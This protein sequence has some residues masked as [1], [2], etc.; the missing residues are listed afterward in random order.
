LFYHEHNRDEAIRELG[1]AIEL[2][3]AYSTAYHWIALMLSAMGRHEEAVRNI[4]K[5][6]ELEPR[7][8]IIQTAA[9][10]VYFYA[11]KYDDALGVADKV[12]ENNEG[13]VPAYKTKRIVFE[14]TGNFS[15][16]LTAYQ[17]ERIYSENT[18]EDDAGWMMIAA[19]VQA[20]GGN[21][22]EAVSNLKRATESAFVKSNLKSFAYEIAL[23]YALLGD[24][25]AT[26]E[27]LKKAKEVNSYGFN[28]AQVD[29]R[30]DKVRENSQFN[31]LFKNQ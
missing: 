28:F 21:R 6:I 20:V 9:G 15:A 25:N 2:N 11:R 8:A 3:P 10:L 26:I 1:R 31:E 16:A 30:F 24:A 29:A 23:A 27:W 13:F 12:L 19:Q 14:A 22:D 5:A 18:D 7:S 17:N 4:K